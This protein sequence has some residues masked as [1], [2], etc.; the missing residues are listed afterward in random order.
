L[1]GTAPHNPSWRHV[2]VAFLVSA[3]CAAACAQITGAS[4]YAQVSSC[5]GPACGAQC[6]MQGG[7]W[8]TLTGACTCG[9]AG[10]P[11]CG[12]VCCSST[13][14]YCVT[15]TTGGERCSACTKAK[16][17]C[18]DVCCEQQTCL[19]ASIGAC[20]VTYGTP[21]QSC[22]GGL[23]CPVPTRGGRGQPPSCCESI[24]VEGGTYTVGRSLD[25]GAHNYCPSSFR[26]SCFTDELPQHPVTVSSYGLDRFE[27][28]VGR[29][30]SFVDSWDYAGLPAGAG[31]NE[32]LAGA[33]WQRAWNASLPKSRGALEEDLA[34]GAGSTWTHARGDG[35]NRPI[36][37]VTW[38]EAFAFCVW[39]GRRLPT[40]AEWEIA[41]ANGIEVD[42][43]PWGTAEP[44]PAL[45]VYDCATDAVPCTDPPGLP[46]AVGSHPG[47]ANRLGHAD[48][49]GNV[50]EWVLDTYAPYITP[51]PP[52]YADVTDGFRAWRG[53]DFADIA[54]YLRTTAR[55]LSTPGSG[56]QASNAG[57]RCASAP[58]P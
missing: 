18:G 26:G 47:G 38:Y 36:N 8:N 24:A 32:H 50:T 21:G 11:M 33:G 52:N 41:A 35:E 58:S 20:G 17:E 27:V 56:G 19:N 5:T 31:G 28:T 13:A 9:D 54:D 16:Y 29:F 49:A 45:A 25:A 22:A 7:I 12:E 15:E 1:T 48:L 42:V 23:S 37:C 40:E 46:A 44:T 57:F 53:G 55:N 43:F 14:P 51:T 39:D 10:A 4:E 6:E 34:C 3:A 30:R 2:L